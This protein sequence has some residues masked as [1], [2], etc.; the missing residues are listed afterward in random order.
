M[1]LAIDIGNTHVV[2]GLYEGEKLVHTWRLRSQSDRTVDEYALDLLGLFDR[3]SIA[4][5]SLNAVVMSCV[6]PALERV[7]VKLSQRYFNLKTLIVNASIIKDIKVEV[8]DPKTVGS[9]RL[10]NAFACMKKY[11]MPG[12]VVDFG[13]ATTFDI[14]DDKASYIGGLIAPGPLLA[15]DAL[16]NRAAMLPK[17]EFAKPQTIIGKNTRDSMLSGVYFGYVSLVDG[18]LCRLED[19]LSALSKDLKIVAT[20]G[21]ARSV[22]QESSKISLIDSSLTLDGLMMIAQQHY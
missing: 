20:G 10:V 7:F 8:D 9:D 5:N 16:A 12:I 21:L 13:T 17:I 14:L 3:N 11:G 6:V 18:I 1:L 4:L 15:L 19:E 22:S 2:F